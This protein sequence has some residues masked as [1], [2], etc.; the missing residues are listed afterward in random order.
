M[1][2]T[3]SS[4]GCSDGERL[5]HPQHTVLRGLQRESG[6]VKALPRAA[7]RDETLCCSDGGIDEAPPWMSCGDCGIDETQTCV[8]FRGSGVD[9]TLY[10][11]GYNNSGINETPPWV[12]CRDGGIDETSSRKHRLAWVSVAVASAKGLCGLWRQWHRQN[13]VLCWPSRGPIANRSR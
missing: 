8:R 3:L 13:I 6:T 1:P 12:G 10:H 11:V 2:E 4:V 9:E 5:W 7:Y